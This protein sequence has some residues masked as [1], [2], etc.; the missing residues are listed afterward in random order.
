MG[1]DVH[2]RLSFFPLF[3]FIWSLEIAFH[4]VMKAL[5]GNQSQLAAISLD[6][7]EKRIRNLPLVLFFLS[8]FPFLKGN[9]T[10]TYVYTHNVSD[11]QR[12]I[13]ILHTTRTYCR[14]VVVKEGPITQVISDAQTLKVK[15]KRRS[16]RGKFTSTIR[17]REKTKCYFLCY[18]EACGCETQCTH[19]HTCTHWKREGRRRLGATSTTSTGE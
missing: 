16:K 3:F 5:M 11:T 8:L 15:R 13:Y 18:T 19:T 6:P 17:E 14:T 9:T 1:K 12:Y 7:A 10:H 4:N 2:P